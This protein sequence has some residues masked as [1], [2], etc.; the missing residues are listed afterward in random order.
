LYSAISVAAALLVILFWPRTAADDTLGH[1][2]QSTPTL[3]PGLEDISDTHANIPDPDELQ[4]MPDFAS[5]ELESD[6]MTAKL[7]DGVVYIRWELD[8]ESDYYVLCVLDSQNGI[9]QRDILWP[10]IDEWELADYQGSRLLLLRYQDMGTADANDDTLAGAYICE[11]PGA[12]T[13]V[14]PTVTP[15]DSL[16]PTPTQSQSV[17][18]ASRTPGPSRTPAP[19]PAPNKYKIIVDKADHAFAVFTYDENGEYTKRVATFPTALGRSSRMTPTGTFQIGKKGEWK[20]W[21]DGTFSPYYTSYT[22]GLYFHGPIYTAK[23]RDTLIR[24]SYEAIGTDASAGCMRTTVAGARW[25][26]FNCP[27]GTVVEI[28]SSSSL[29]SSVSKPAIDEN[30]PNWDPTDPD[31]PGT[32][33]ATPTPETTPT[34]APAETPTPVET[35][36]PDATPTTTPVD[37]A[38]ATSTA[39]ETSG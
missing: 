30:Y 27:A 25:V 34:S 6:M 33:P 9:L 11:T 17:S 32:P 5:L 8:P 13:Q 19:T 10:D 35:P 29:V 2:A 20:K 24:S 37:T 31:K 21:S 1:T 12:A 26:Y 14:T 38:S 28:V 4:A 23:S 39:C 22:S 36:T 7:T 15:E 18:T 16:A 3:T